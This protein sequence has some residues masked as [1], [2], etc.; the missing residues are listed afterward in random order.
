MHYHGGGL[1]LCTYQV[2]IMWAGLEV[3]VEIS[4]DTSDWDPASNRYWQIVSSSVNHMDTA[5]RLLY[6]GES[7]NCYPMLDADY[8]VDSLCH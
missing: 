6:Y 2:P 4:H 5:M 1:T 7:A 3:T 8:D